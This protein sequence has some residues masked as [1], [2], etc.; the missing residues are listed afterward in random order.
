MCLMLNLRPSG[1]ALSDALRAFMQHIVIMCD[2]MERHQR[3]HVLK[4]IYTA[5]H[6]LAIMREVRSVC[7]MRMPSRLVFRLTL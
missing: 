6:A 1:K 5:S 4:C 3:R 2:L 7:N